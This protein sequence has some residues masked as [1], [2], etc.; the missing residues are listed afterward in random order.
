[1]NDR[2]VV[3]HLTA[4]VAA[5]LL[6]RGFGQGHATMTGAR[7]PGRIWWWYSIR[8]AAEFLRGAESLTLSLGDGDNHR[9]L[10]RFERLD[11]LRK[12]KVPQRHPNARHRAW[13]RLWYLFDASW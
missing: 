7:L 4:S 2:I 11:A 12:T 9:C 1:M 10:A 6:W 5:P 3:Y 8:T 13:D